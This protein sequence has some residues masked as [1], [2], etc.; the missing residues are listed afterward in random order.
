MVLLVLSK[1]M[2]QTS[3]ITTDKY[4]TNFPFLLADNFAY[5]K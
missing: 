1:L 3:F 2:L 5:F 4:K